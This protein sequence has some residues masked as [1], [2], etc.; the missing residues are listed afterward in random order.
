[1]VRAFFIDKL[2]VPVQTYLKQG[3][4][5][6]K[7]AEGFAWGIVLGFIP[8]L[9]S[10]TI[11]C[12]VASFT[13]KINMAVI[14]LINWFVYPLQ[15]ILFFPF[16]KLGGKITNSPVP[17]S[18]SQI[19]LMIETDFLGFLKQFALANLGGIFIWLLVA[20]PIWYITLITLNKLFKSINLKRQTIQKK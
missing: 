17:F 12:M 3:L 18:I 13:R 10:T 4:S 16:L 11:L 9:G 15:L 20:I 14:Q 5:P 2:Y 6:I 1:M 7:L 19:K 8:L